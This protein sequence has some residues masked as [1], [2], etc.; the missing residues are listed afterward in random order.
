MTE[1]AVEVEN[2]S[3][4]FEDHVALTDLSLRIQKNSFIAIVGPNGAGKSTFLKVLLGLIK[5]TTG[6]VKIFG[7]TP[8]QVDPNLIGYVPQFKTM[9]RSFPAVSLRVEARFLAA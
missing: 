7:R 2:L 1:F 5:P 3:I 8:Q 6:A 9:D 4:K